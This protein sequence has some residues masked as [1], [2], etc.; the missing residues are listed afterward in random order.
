MPALEPTRP[1]SAINTP[2]EHNFQVVYT[3]PEAS[4]QYYSVI[5]AEFSSTDD[6]TI[7]DVSGYL[8][9]PARSGFINVFGEGDV[10]INISSNGTTY[11]SDIT[12]FRNDIFKIDGLLVDKIKLTHTGS[13]S[14][15]RV[16]LV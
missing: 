3:Q 16:F 4:T 13:D 10:D 7:L 8:G 15:Y 11:G 12:L 1:V 9:Y 6:Q 5:D 14:A 2:N